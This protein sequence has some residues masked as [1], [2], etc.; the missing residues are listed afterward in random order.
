MLI[1]Q[2]SQCLFFLLNFFSQRY[3]I[4]SR[5]METEIQVGMR[6]WV[7]SRDSRGT[8]RWIG[9]LEGLESL[10][11]GIELDK[12]VGSHSG[13]YLGRSLF[14]TKD[15]NRGIFLKREKVDLGITFMAA[16]ERRYIKPQ[17][18]DVNVEI[19]GKEMAE[20]FFAE[21]I[22]DLLE[23]SLNQMNVYSLVVGDRQFLNLQRLSL[24]ENLLY[25]LSDILRLC[26]EIPTLSDL[27]VSG[28]E[29]TYFSSCPSPDNPPTSLKTIVLNDCTFLHG[30]NLYSFLSYLGC[31]L[32]CVNLD[33]A[34]GL[35]WSAWPP[36]S[37]SS[38]SLQYANLE[39]WSILSSVVSSLPNLT[40]LDISGN[41]ALGDLS[42][43][44]Q[45]V[46]TNL[47]VLGLSACGLTQWSSLR[48]LS[49][50]ASQ[51]SSL[52][53]ADNAVYGNIRSGLQ[54]S[55]IIAAFPTLELL[56]NATISSAQRREAERYVAT[57]LQSVKVEHAW[58]K[59]AIAFERQTWLTS[60]YSIE[61]TTL[62]ESSAAHV[63]RTSRL[64]LGLR[65]VT[66]TGEVVPIKVPLNC[67]YEDLHAIVSRKIKWPLEA[68]EMALSFS[69]TNSSEDQIQTCDDDFIGNSGICDGWFVHIVL[70]S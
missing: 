11:V 22:F 55:V 27:D 59:E 8:V 57:R 19:V 4:P 36:L 69:P 67:R 3:S 15:L 39:S 54:R 49:Q 7:P 68:S 53:L 18:E 46:F 61:R 47:R 17:Q 56:N 2:C 43:D 6:V 24:R 60:T 50:A 48:F 23:V 5:L 10:R 35:D 64:T 25:D 41:E 33:R 31:S 52:R 40:S 51:I 26:V 28:N 20:M 14:L 13:E 9:H 32:T 63:P 16:I 12:P 1:F 34:S 44:N 62:E 29:F 42:V 58:M 30:S 66:P 38:L 70:N 37:I 65:V 45:N 21:N